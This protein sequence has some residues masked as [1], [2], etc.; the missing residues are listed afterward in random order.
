MHRALAV[1]RE[2]GDLRN[3]GRSHGDLALFHR[4]V[5]NE[6]KALEHYAETLATA[7]S[8]GDRRSEGSALVGIGNIHR[9]A[10]RY[11]AAEA[12]YRQGLVLQKETGDYRSVV[13]NMGYLGMI[14]FHQG[15]T[16]AAVEHLEAAIAVCDRQEPAIASS[17]RSALA[18][19]RAEQGAFDT[20]RALLTKAEGQ[21]RGV[22]PPAL[23]KVLCKRALVEHRAGDPSAASSALAEAE[24][25][26]L[27]LE[28][29]AETDLGA[30]IRGARAALDGTDD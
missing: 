10:G 5:G 15:D 9:E 1:S 18:I 7:R 23:A 4:E 30:E 2:V 16:T 17:F 19:I 22:Y 24:A 14:L 29:G 20:A 28:A 26:A 6:T 12:H 8:L 11:A 3:E 13:A 21:L 27:D 25:I